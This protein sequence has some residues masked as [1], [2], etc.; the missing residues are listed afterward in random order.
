MWEWEWEW[1]WDYIEL[2]TWVLYV[3]MYY[4]WITLLL[5]NDGHLPHDAMNI[6]FYCGCV[7]GVVER[8]K[9]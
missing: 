8:K 3:C 9:S 6:F 1:E 5:T 7:F 4:E 2:W